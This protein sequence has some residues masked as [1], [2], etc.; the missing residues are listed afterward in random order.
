MAFPKSYAITNKTTRVL[1]MN[2]W[3]FGFTG[4]HHWLRAKTN[5]MVT[6]RVNFAENYFGLWPPV[7]IGQEAINAIVMAA[8]GK[9]A[10]RCRIPTA[11]PSRPAAKPSHP[12]HASASVY[13]DLADVGSGQSE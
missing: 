12:P 7:S 8:C 10:Q 4:R 5:R 1:N 9:A 13:G 6:F 11:K 3:F 2:G